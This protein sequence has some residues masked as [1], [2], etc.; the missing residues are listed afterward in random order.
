[1]HQRGLSD[2]SSRRSEREREPAR[3]ERELPV[4]SESS[5]DDSSA[6]PTIFDRSVV[7]GASV[8]RPD[9]AAGEGSEDAWTELKVRL[10]FHVLVLIAFAHEAGCVCVYYI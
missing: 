6:A 4:H 7:N 8:A 1:V 10:F 3:D 9:S 5:S 2:A